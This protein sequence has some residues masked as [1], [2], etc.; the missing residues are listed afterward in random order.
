MAVL[1]VEPSSTTTISENF[2]ELAAKYFFTAV[3]LGDSRSAS[4]KAGM[5]TEIDRR[6]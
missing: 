4:L 1:S 6:R 5:T 2:Q 3:R